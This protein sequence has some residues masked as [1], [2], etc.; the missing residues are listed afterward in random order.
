MSISVTQHID[1]RGST[2]NTSDEGESKDDQVG[3]MWMRLMAVTGGQESLTPRGLSS[4][5]PP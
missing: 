3:E 5:A 4:M 1:N 2:G